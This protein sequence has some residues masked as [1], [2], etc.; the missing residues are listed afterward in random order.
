MNGDRS[1][2]TPLN[3]V[4]KTIKATGRDMLE[5]YQETPRGGLAVNVTV[6]WTGDIY[7]S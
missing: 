6:R 1:H 7:I 3:K 5:K 2:F 4:I